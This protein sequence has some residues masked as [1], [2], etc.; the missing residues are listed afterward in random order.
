MKKKPIILRILPWVLLA[1]VVGGLVYVGY[2]LWGRPEGEPLYT[3][4]ILRYEA[5][6]DQPVVLDNGKLHLEL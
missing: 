5:E 1:A 6:D 3:A 4:E 2:L